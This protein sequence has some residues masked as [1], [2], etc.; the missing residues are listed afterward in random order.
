MKGFLRPML[1]SLES[2]RR[3]GVH[4]GIPNDESLLPR[5]A[6]S[7]RS[8]NKHRRKERRNGG[9]NIEEEGKQFFYKNI[10]VCM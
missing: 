5:I 6:R 9:G 1:K 3:A 2:R 4:Y 7:R 10:N 8:R